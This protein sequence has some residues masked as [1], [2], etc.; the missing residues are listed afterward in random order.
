LRARTGNCSRAVPAILA[1][2]RQMSVTLGSDIQVLAPEGARQAGQWTSAR[3]DACW[4]R[5]RMGGR[6]GFC[7]EKYRSG[8]PEWHRQ[9]Q[10]GPKRETG[11]EAMIGGTMETEKHQVNSTGNP[12]PAARAAG[13][14]APAATTDGAQR[15]S[16][17]DRRPGQEP[18]AGQEGR[19]D[20][21]RG[22][23]RT[24]RARGN[25]A[26]RAEPRTRQ[27]FP[28]K[29]RRTDPPRMGRVIGRRRPE[30]AGPTP[31]SP[32]RDAGTGSVARGRAAPGKV[33][34]NGSGA[35][36]ILPA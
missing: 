17:R 28:R 19:R 11:P 13:D 31:A 3:M 32:E 24:D 22:R 15:G 36:R 35:C 1:R 10:H 18:R 5:I 4:W 9:A 16:S 7:P 8:A 34:R 14:G 20:G 26:A 12:R 6:N 33:S 27:A 30:A 29:P 23:S 21:S 2:W 25:A